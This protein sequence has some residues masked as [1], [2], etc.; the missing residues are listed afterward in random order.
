M[1]YIHPDHLNTP[2]MI[3]DQAGNTVWRWDNQ[4]PFGSD[5]PNDDPDS[6]GSPFVFNL[7]FPGQ[8]FDR[9]TNL[10]YNMMRDYDSSIGRYVESDPVGLVAGL[11]TYAYA[12][13]APLLTIDP[14]GLCPSEFD[15]GWFLSTIT[16][17]RHSP[18][19]SQCQLHQ[20]RSRATGVLVSKS[21]SCECGASSMTCIYSVKWEE[22]HRTR[23]AD[24][25]RRVA[26]GDWSQWQNYLESDW[27]LFSYT[28]DCKTQE[29][30]P[31]AKKL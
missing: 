10:A 3:A 9:E 29:L 11:N 12:D 6:T 21:G 30:G 15:T 22:Y 27:G 25:K 28:Y 13:D 18:T 14:A 31:P 5:L 16:F 20:Q 4:E 24:C 2:R 19:F 1:Y 26:T 8:Y 17:Q 23:A 7:R